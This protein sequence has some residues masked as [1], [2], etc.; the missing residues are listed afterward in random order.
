MDSTQARGVAAGRIWI[1]CTGQGGA[2]RARGAPRPPLPCRRRNWF[3]GAPSGGTRPAAP[4]C[5]CSGPGRTARGHARKHR[6]GHGQLRIST[7]YKAWPQDD[8]FRRCVRETPQV[9]A[10]RRRD[11]RSTNRAT[12]LV[13]APHGQQLAA[14]RPGHC[15]HPEPDRRRR[16]PAQA[17]SKENIKE[18]KW[19]HALK[20][21]RFL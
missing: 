1:F 15:F 18:K 3:L 16:E 9:R 4:R 2:K 6:H 12:D 19:M 13:E 10:V 14:G 20:Q 21:W 5:D 7:I 17:A 11:G 8:S